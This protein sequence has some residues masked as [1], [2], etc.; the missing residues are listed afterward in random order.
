MEPGR[1]LNLVPL[2]SFLLLLLVNSTNALCVPRNSSSASTPKSSPPQAPPS[3][4]QPHV[5]KLPKFIYTSHADTPAGAPQ[6]SA[7]S[8]GGSPLD[9]LLGAAT[10]A[11]CAKTDYPDVCESSLKPYKLDVGS[12]SPTSVVGMLLRACTEQ[13]SAA[14]KE[15]AKLI[16]D[17]S[18]D[19][20]LRSYVKV[21]RE[22]YSDALNNLEDAVAALASGDKNSFNI[23]VSAAMT[24]FV[25]CEDGFEEMDTVSPLKAFDGNLKE[26]ASNILA[27]AS[28][29]Q[30]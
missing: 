24:D 17:S 13:T 12:I 21:C 15:A 6:Q 28:A 5:L 27:V 11:I 20:T 26:I 4:V 10:K 7:P 18:I 3:N 29:I 25:S 1:Q 8:G 16:A 30:F 2:A 14:T 9:S 22:S 19:D 23:M